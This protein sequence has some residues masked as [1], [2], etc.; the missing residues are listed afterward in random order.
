MSEEYRV[1]RQSLQDASK[2]ILDAAQEWQQITATLANAKLSENDLGVIGKKAN[3][4]ARYN[5]GVDAVWRSINDGMNNIILMQLALDAVA[6]CYG[7]AEEDAR[8]TIDSL[9]KVIE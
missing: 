9:R 2:Y 4:V 3:I 5:G 6:A 1:H 8:K 7:L